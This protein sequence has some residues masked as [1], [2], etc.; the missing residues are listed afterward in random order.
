VAVVVGQDTSELAN[1]LLGELVV[2]KV[3][4]C[5]GSLEEVVEGNLPWRASSIF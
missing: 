1:T 4:S 3:A 5:M 2:G